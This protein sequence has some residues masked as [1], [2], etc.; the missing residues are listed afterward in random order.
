MRLDWERYLEHLRNDGARLADAA[1]DH[2]DDTA[3]WCPGWVGRDVVAHT[4]IVH[5]H[6]LAIVAGG[7]SESPEPETPPAGDDAL[8]VWYR[9]GLTSLLA[10]LTTADPS[11]PV[12]TWHRADQSVG[13]WIRRMAHETAIHR[14]DA[15]SA[16]GAIT[17][18]DP[19]LAA[20]GV[21]EV[22][23]PI[24]CAYTDEPHWGFEADGR[25]AELRMADT[26][27]TRSLA[28]G[29]GTHG[30]GWLYH[31]GAAAGP[32]TVI[33]APA[34]DLDLWAWGRADGSALA[35][36]GDAAIAEGIRALAAEATG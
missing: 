34:S 7:L 17:P 6:K 31:A 36:T 13:F 35:V 2:L 21:D 27:D 33:E 5:R 16:S 4:G 15:E 9:E 24:M 28:F 19:A 1:A 12:F 8:L 22:L 3:P 11:A 14:I 30:P 23:G 18:L 32:I 20:D 29:M 10:V 25:T 26:G